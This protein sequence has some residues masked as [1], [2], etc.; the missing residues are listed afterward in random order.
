MTDEG[1][2]KNGRMRERKKGKEIGITKINKE[3]KK[4]LLYTL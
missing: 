1:K 2:G 4:E 3:R